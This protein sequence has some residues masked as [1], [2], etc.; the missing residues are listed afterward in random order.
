MNDKK[1]SFHY[2]L[3]FLISGLWITS[4]L[5]AYFMNYHIALENHFLIEQYKIY[6]PF[7]IIFWWANYADVTIK[8]IRKVYF[9]LVLYWFICFIFLYCLNFSRA[10]ETVHGT[11]EWLEKDVDLKRAKLLKNSAGGKNKG[12]VLGLSKD[13]KY[14]MHDGPEHLLVMAP[15]RTG[16]GVGIIIPTL[17]TWEHSVVITDIKGENWGITSGF[18]KKIGQKVLHFNPTD[19]TGITCKFNPLEEIRIKTSYEVQDVQNL[20]Q[21]L[22]DPDGKGS[23]DHWTQSAL[24]FIT[25]AILHLLYMKFEP[26]LGD[27]IDLLTGDDFDNFLIETISYKHGNNGDFLNEYGTEESTHP[28]VKH[29]MVEMLNKAD[30]ERASVLSSAIVKLSL[31]R[32]PIIRKNISKSDFKIFDLMNDDDPVSLYLVTPPSDLDRTRPLMRIIIEQIVRLLTSKMEFK[33]GK[34]VKNYKHRLLLLLDEFPALG[35]IESFE[36]ALAFIAGYGI[37]A[38]IITQTVNQLYKEYTVNNSIIDNCHVRVFYTPNDE[39]TPEVISKMLGTKTEKV[40]NE[41]WKGIKW[42]SDFNYSTNLVARPLLTPGEISKLPFEKEIIFVAGNSPIYADK[43][44][45]FQDENFMKRCIAQPEKSDVIQIRNN[46]NKKI[47][48]EKEGNNFDK[49]A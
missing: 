29:S 42:L 46:E 32:D 6:E 12:V 19:S 20:A 45:Y 21:V 25:G 2:F 24:G 40:T 47:K 11:A 10:K 30:K 1:K 17:L 8:E 14:L 23:N 26:N 49:K 34:P 15:T 18:R 44:M 13:K 22:L 37:K 4:Q 48:L 35:K 38:L 43:I 28:V 36:K 5:Y 7:S 33:E 3:F 31:Y 27:L 41:S 9:F 16:K 39:K